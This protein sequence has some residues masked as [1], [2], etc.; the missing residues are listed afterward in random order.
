MRTGRCYCGAVRY[1][2]DGALGPAANCHCRF[3]RRVHGAA[4][5]T[6][7]VVRSANLHLTTGEGA[8][9]EYR[10]REGARYFCERC[11]GRLFNR[12]ASNPGITMLMLAS[13]DDEPEAGPVVHINV[14]S[15]APWYEILDDLPQFPGLPP[16]AVS[17]LES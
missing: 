8:V 3:C 2:L 17:V 15:K 14:E 1:R 5:V 9:R 13:L 11:G 7:A 16:Q 10:T 6:A 12:P 4:F